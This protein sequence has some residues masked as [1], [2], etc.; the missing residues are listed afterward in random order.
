MNYK[1]LI[2]I[3]L[4]MSINTSFSQVSKTVNHI[5][6]LIKNYD[7]LHDYG[8][9]LLAYMKSAIDNS[10]STNSISTEYESAF[11]SF[12][13]VSIITTLL[14]GIITTLKVY[15]VIS[16]SEDRLLAKYI[17]QAHLDDCLGIIDKSI[18]VINI[19]ISDV[20]RP[21]VAQTLN[22][23]KDELRLLKTSLIDIPW[24]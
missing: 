12:R 4:L 17:I 8:D 19:D 13:E 11:S 22:R 6:I 24:N 15:S 16:S 14:L 2:I 9:D 20:K 7:T 5:G 3:F 23:V 21:G 18:K 1:I 10:I